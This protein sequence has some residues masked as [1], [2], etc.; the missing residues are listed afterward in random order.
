M[1]DFYGLDWTLRLYYQL[2]KESATWPRLC[3]LVCAN[4]NLDICDAENIPRFSKSYQKI[5]FSI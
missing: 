5:Q 3:K 2:S 1:R 4:G